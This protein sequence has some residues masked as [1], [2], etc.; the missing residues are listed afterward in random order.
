MQKHLQKL[1]LIV[2][3]M[4]VPWV[5]QAQT[6]D[7]ISTFPYTCDFEDPGDTALWVTLNGTQENGWY[8]GS[9]VN[10]TTGG[11][12]ALYVSNNSGTSNA[13]GVTTATAS[14]SWAYERF[15]FSAG[16]YN[17]SLKWRCT[18]EQDGDPYDFFRVFIVPDATTLT[19]GALPS[20]SYTWSNQFMSDIPTGWIGINGTET[21]FCGQS[22][23]TTLNSE[24]T[25]T[26]AGNY[27]L[28]FLWLN[29]DNVFN[30]P[31][32]AIDDI[33]ISVNSCP[34]PT[35]LHVV[36]ATT[37][38]IAFSF[39]NVGTASQ[40]VLE[41]DTV[42]FV[43]GAGLGN[44][45]YLSNSSS[46]I[47][48]SLTGLDSGVF[49]YIYLRA[50]CGGGDTSAYISLVAATLASSG[51]LPYSCGFEGPGDN[52][53]DLINGTQ[54]NKW[55]VGTA[56]H[57]SGS[58][59]LYISDNNGVS[60]SY[61]GTSES[62]VFA[63][64]EFVLPQSGEYAFSYDWKCNGES[65]FDFMRAALVP[66]TTV[67][68]AGGYCGFD[69][70][71]A[72]PAGGI[73]LDGG[74]R[75][76]LQTTWQTMTGTFLITTPGTYKWV[77]MWRNDGSV[78][79]QP[80]I[81][82][83][84]VFLQLN[85]CPAPTVYVDHT[86]P[87]SIILAWHPNGEET[88]WE[89]T[90]DSIQVV[91][92]DTTYAFGNLLSNT[93]YHFTVRAICGDG[94]TSMPATIIQ[95]TPCGY[96]TSLP[97]TET[98]E[99]QSTGSSTTGSAFITCWSRLNNGTS[100]G[101]YPYVSSSSSYNHTPGGTKGLYWYNTTTT[102]GYGDYQCVVLPGVDTDIHPINT[103]QLS[104]WARSSSTS[105]YPVFYVGVMTNPGDIN[106]F[107]PYDT[108]SL[109]NNTSFR[110]FITKFENYTGAGNF[111]ALKA[112]RPSSSWY[113]YVD[114]FRLEVAPDCPR[115]ED[116]VVTGV[117]TDGATITWTDTTNATAWEVEYG[118]AGFS[119]GDT[120]ANIVYASD[121]TVTL[122]GLNP[123]T[124]YDV[125]ITVDCPAG[126]GG[127]NNTTFRT[128]CTDLD[129]LPFVET[130]ESQPTGSS[131]TGS[132]FANCW[133]HLNNG[134]SYG[135]YPYVGN[136]TTYNHTSGG[137]RGLYWY[138]TTTTGTYGDYMVAV[139]PGVDT[140]NYPINT[141]VVRF[142]AKPSSTSYSPIFYVGVM[143][144][145]TDITTFQYVDTVSVG[146]ST[147]WTEFEAPLSQFTGSGRFV[148]IRANRASSWTA[149][150][151]DISLD[152]I[153]GCLRTSELTQTDATLSSVTIDWTE[154]GEAT[155]WVLEYDTVDFIPG[156]GMGTVITA[157][158][159]PYT[160]TGL[161]SAHSYYI[162]LHADCGNGDTSE[163]RSLVART[164]AA[165]PATIPYSC[166]FEANGPNGWNLMNGNQTNIWYVGT[167]VNHGGSQSMYISN[168][169]GVSN[170][171]NTSSISYAY[172]VRT[173]DFTDSGEF[174]YSYDWKGVGESHYY[175]FTRVFLSPVGYQWTENNNPAGSTYD[176]SSWTCP[177]GWIELTEAFGTPA[178]LAQSSTWRRVT[179]T[180]TL[181]TPAVYNLVFAWAN[182]GS[183]GTQ[184]PTAID[185]VSIVRN[186]CPSPTLSLTNSSMDTVGVAWT[187][188][189]GA[190]N[191]QL[192]VGPVGFDPDTVVSG[193]INLTN[194]SYDF[195]TLSPT[196]T[197][198]IYVRTDCGPD[199]YSY[200]A[201]PLTVRPGSINMAVTGTDSIRACSITVYDDGGPLGTYSHNANSTL[202]IRAPHPDS[203]FAFSGSAYTES[204]IDYLRIYDGEGTGGTL[205]WQ[206]STTSAAESIPFTTSTS[207]VITLLWHT[208]GSIT[209]DG[210]ELNVSCQSA[211]RCN[212]IT[213]LQVTHVAG[214]SALLSWST[215]TGNTGGDPAY[216]TVTLNGVT[217]TTTE[218]PYWLTGL[219]PQT[220]YT[221]TVQG[222][223]A[224]E[225]T[226]FAITDYFRTNCP[227]GGDVDIS[228][229]TG[230]NVY[231]PLNA[232]VNYSY[233]QEIYN[234]SQL[235]G[236][237]TILGVAYHF[238]SSGCSTRNI[239]L[240][241]GEVTRS[242]L[243]SDTSYIPI[244]D[245]HLVYTGTFSG[246]A[247]TWDTI[248]LDSSFYYSGMGNLVVALDDN[249]G[250]TGSANFYTTSLTGADRA[251]HFHNS[252]DINPASPSGTTQHY[253]GVQN[254][255]RFIAECDS[256]ATC[257]PPNVA[258]FESH[259]TNALVSWAPGLN[260]TSWDVA[261]KVQND[262]AW[263]VDA[264]NHPFTT[265][266]VTGLDPL[267][268]YI[269]RVT[270]NCTDT[271]MEGF[272]SARTAMCDN[273][274]SVA[275]GNESSSGTTY[276]AP[277]NN[278]YNYTL[279][280]M[281]VDSAEIGGPM[282]IEYISF[283]YN[284]TTAMT[285]KTNCTIYLQPTTLS[286]FSSSSD[287]VALDSATA[288]R[289][290]TGPL[291]CSQGWNNFAFDTTYHYDGTSNLLVIVDDNSGTYNTSSDI[292]KTQSCSGNKT[293]YYYSDTY[294]PDP[295][296]ITSSY[297]GTKSVAAWR[298]VM[299]LLWCAPVCP[300]PVITSISH[301]HE[302]AT[303]TWSGDG[304]AY[305]VN[306]KE[307]A[308]P[309]WPAADIVVTG[310]T[311]TFT[312]LMPATSYT[313]RVRQDCSADSLGYSEWTVNGFL[314]DSLPCFAPDSLHVTG[315]TNA[316]ATLDW[317][318]RGYETM[319]EIHV[320]TS[321]GV[322]S[323]YTA[324]SHPATVG[325]FTANTTYNASVRPLCGTLGNIEGEWG[326][327]IV[328]T[329]AVCPDVTGLGTRN[330]TAN[331]VDV[332][333]NPDPLAQQW[334][335][336]YGFHGFD[337]GTGT[338]VTTSL[339][340]YTI[341]GLLDDMEYDFR[342]RA[343]CGDD[344]QSEGWAT[345][346]ATTLE[347]G[348]PCDAPTAVN[349]VAAGNAATV[350]WTANTGNLSFVLEYGTRG[351]A[352]GSGTTVNATASP[353]TISNLAYETAYDVYVKAN[354][355]DNTSSAWSA[356]A[357][358]TTEA[359]GSE[360]CD[361]V[362]DL[363]ATNVTESAA[364]LTWT[365]GNSGDEWEV[366][367]TTAAGAT[368]SENSTTERQFQ[369]T[370]L[371]PG[372]AYVA[373]VRTV[374]G[375]GQYSDFASV[376]FT[377]NS[378]GIADV[379]APACTIY[380]NPTSGATTV[381]VS[382]ISGKVRIAIVDMNGREVT[383]ETLDCS[384]DCAK[385]MSVDNLAQ[386]AYFVRITGENAN[387]VRKLIV[388]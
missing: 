230:S 172:A 142:W 107:T 214:T 178:N 100:Y 329:T 244:S 235:S 186:A 260:E 137:S 184:P 50:D 307:S 85:S 242:H 185:N 105:Y 358:F 347:G 268:N 8:I 236:P 215:S 237:M 111:I 320:W 56:A 299:Q 343:V 379:T 161:D 76:N 367:L 48:D 218:N 324:T 253:T 364:L 3:M 163:N 302:N 135:G 160:I 159:H 47:T 191:Y 313:F 187:D 339:T 68:T 23:F 305:E 352:L 132:P 152:V 195:T 124:E 224:S 200:W 96:L 146:N 44:L 288:V 52:D 59:G 166:D 273:I 119:L 282:D 2:A 40:W 157:T 383:S 303:I 264:T 46:T 130:F 296:T 117:T 317:S 53:W 180:F 41:Y 158:T 113:A 183:G 139:L 190:G 376:S 322:D 205:L 98:F 323:V 103:L 1:L 332:Y 334:I 363:A 169:N 356:V 220:P 256:N 140:D 249:T 73:A 102:S 310:N 351:F 138:N 168:N 151:D 276:Y 361:P 170:A 27:K 36:N 365:P 106:T 211:P 291:N 209:Y 150:M 84:N 19:A 164:L 121:T 204:S 309:T 51:G 153:R 213:N 222:V 388:R 374:C 349:A 5:T 156:T 281:I 227:M 78:T 101:G 192:V 373:K 108:I 262:T 331:S 83:D 245:L 255:T 93:N 248:W 295:A 24:F 88:M 385:T 221:V 210:F 293:L 122:T 72:M 143:S 62:Y 232:Q 306:I 316:T 17:I 82:I 284:Y 344:W 125:Y 203:L 173:I 116:I 270:A 58:K 321:G 387:M 217:D 118:P 202:I 345:T 120:S 115:V 325:G 22:S 336:E 350:S 14:Y 368:V 318:P 15:A 69:N 226:S 61:D 292:F 54:T 6:P 29:D 250:Y 194:T 28:V 175:D 126:V 354:C 335:I 79:N 285:A 341:N 128:L 369:L 133:H 177:T 154:M 283:Y 231:Y 208:D 311:Y 239:C 34:A 55:Y 38:S 94:D 43:P 328:F 123:N 199:G 75:V 259:A 360:D 274:V 258:V 269:F 381:S 20:T 330:V 71:S 181:S 64:K 233:T 136:S 333:W 26:T 289:V 380:P 57:S 110:E 372:T 37:T 254:D 134:T 16:S 338:Q 240:Y 65:S 384:G 298:P 104:F 301:T 271:T 87:D 228:G 13:Y 63:V 21:Y 229:G 80:P 257:L 114:D 314:T 91:L 319:W 129:S 278:L 265:Y 263:T 346:S 294:N 252:V 201:G 165:S 99:S 67:L 127:V 247:Q 189:A 179:G 340:T 275:T 342:V 12:N 131:S 174:A 272:E 277:V 144:D 371:T 238:Q 25:I 9:A 326:D 77:F 92:Y 246:V 176:F 35:N 308:A 30:N 251:I 290:Y 188:P 198:D 45:V 70:A 362:T 11:S 327:T 141:L 241:L 375:D 4:L 182:D 223:C 155:Q 32:A 359:Q 49:Y 97:F 366:V 267:T 286:A 109:G 216:Y 7:S 81:A 370:G 206:T 193:I 212:S 66:E 167:A 196:T 31:P 304:S 377:T 378:V 382:G 315:I 225:G 42:D 357:S 386:G 197:Y 219:T 171:Y 337:L 266:T 297:S 145:P 60:N 149:Y 33:T 95:R 300:Q 280:E 148:A 353:V 18:G 355:A 162:Y 147:T 287:V 39:D 348:V 74:Y 90:S 279:S 261:H 112:V 243:S 207:S 10:A 312:G 89:L 86:S 234:A